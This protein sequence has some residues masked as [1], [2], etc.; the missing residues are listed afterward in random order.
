[1]LDAAHQFCFVDRNVPHIYASLLAENAE[2]R[3]LPDS[4]AD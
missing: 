1:L 4:P 2:R 3:R